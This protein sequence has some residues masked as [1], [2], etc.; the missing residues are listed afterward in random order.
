M[1]KNLLLAG[2]SIVLGLIMTELAL[3]WTT[4]FPTT[5]MKNTIYDEILE[6]KM[7]PEAEGI[8]ENGF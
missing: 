2:I 8:D 4:P 3:R 6:Y 1:K 5:L 7:N